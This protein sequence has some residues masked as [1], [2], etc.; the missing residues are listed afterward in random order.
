MK[1]HLLVL[2]ALCAMHLAGVTAWGAVAAVGQWDRF[3]AAL[4]NPK[5]YDDPYRETMLRATYTRPDG[6]TVDFRGFYDGGPTWKI[7]FMPDQIGTW[8]YEASFSDGSAGTSGTFECVPSE[9][10]GMVAKDEANPMWFGFK[11]GRHTLVRG[12]HVGDRFFAANWPGAQRT[13]FLDWA[14]GQGYNLLSIASHYLNR[15]AKGRGRGWQT[16]DLWPLNAAEYQR[17][18][19]LL[20]DLAARRILVFPFA[21]FFGQ[22]SDFPRDPADQERYVRYTLAR[23]GPYWNVLFN[24]A[25]PEPNVGKKWMPDE[26]VVRLGRMIRDLDVF[27]HLLSVHNRTGDDPYRDADW[28]SYGVLQGPK[29]LDRARLS[30][31]LLR[32]HH[33]AKPLLA[34]E[35]L[36]P[37]NINHPNYTE[38]DIRKN[39][40]VI[41]TAA[42]ALCFADMN[43]DSSTGFSGSMDLAEKVQARHD[44]VKRVWDFFETVPFYRMS[45]RQDL[46]SAGFCLAEPGKEYLVYL[47]K[48]GAVDVATEGGPYREQW[49]DARDPTKRRDVGMTADGKRLASPNEGED[50]LLH[51]RKP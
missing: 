9:L 31:T 39:A 41:M 10:P 13:A 29:T 44:I 23:L 46:V 18:E 37:G 21:G 45:P 11:G 27:G 4:E 12:L 32:N 43:G 40:F 49:I 6:R 28:T 38:T 36:W 33:G 1:R 47:E 15:D 5:R 22:S 25:G 19:R 8:K 24:V 51:L 42:T 30:A 14:Q 26:E 3:E 34:Q 2:A 20:D 7:R 48:P 35:T 17:M 16:P 50:W